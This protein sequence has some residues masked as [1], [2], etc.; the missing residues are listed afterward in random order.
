MM[1]LLAAEGI[2]V[3][4][5]RVA[6]FLRRVCTDIHSRRVISTQSLTNPIPYSA[7][8]PGDK[9]HVDQNE[10]LIMFGITH[11]CAI[12]GHS[13]MIIGFVTMPMKNYVII[14]EELYM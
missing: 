3:S 10:K 8:Y 9:L 11:V 7:S 13:G 1:G 12:D 14:Y 6:S 5:K 4:E 2:R